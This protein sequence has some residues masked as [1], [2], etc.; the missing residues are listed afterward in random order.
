[1]QKIKVPESKDRA[2]PWTNL[3]FKG[4]LQFVSDLFLPLF[5][6]DLTETFHRLKQE[7][8]SAYIHFKVGQLRYLCVY[9]YLMV[10]IILQVA[11][12]S[13]M[14]DSFLALTAYFSNSF[15]KCTLIHLDRV[16]D[17]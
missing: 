4:E 17:S 11:L 8:D 3:S 9:I 7:H 12:Y 13:F 16:W 6:R 15:S 14:C 2:V 5:R 1:M 10:N